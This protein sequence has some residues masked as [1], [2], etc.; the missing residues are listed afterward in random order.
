[1][2]ANLELREQSIVQDISGKEETSGD[3]TVLSVIFKENAPSTL[4][5][6]NSFNMLEV[7][8]ELASGEA[9]LA[10]MDPTI[11]S[12]VALD[13][14]ESE[15]LVSKE[16]AC[17]VDSTNCEFSSVENRQPQFSVKLVE[18]VSAS[19]EMLITNKLVE[20]VTVTEMLGPDKGKIK[21]A[22]SSKHCSE[23]SKKSVQ[24]LSKYWGDMVD[25][26]HTTDGTMDPDTDTEKMNMHPVALKFLEAQS[27]A[28][29][30]RKSKK[31][32]AN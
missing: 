20:P 23:A 24:I 18:Y 3:V 1:M 28:K 22:N 29:S 26:D 31:N 8:N 19:V 15:K 10:D 9:C 17:L 5:L 11:S 25:S 4:V 7:E 6:N 2:H 12:K 30:S 27:D 14:T 13:S 16:S 21:K 32:K